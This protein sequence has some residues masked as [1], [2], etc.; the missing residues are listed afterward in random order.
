MFDVCKFKVR[1]VNEKESFI[2]RIRSN[3]TVQYQGLR[4]PNVTI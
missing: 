3:L 2:I 4:T 1:A